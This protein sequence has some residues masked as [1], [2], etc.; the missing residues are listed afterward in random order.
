MTSAKSLIEAWQSEEIPPFRSIRIPGIANPIELLL[1]A[2]MERLRD[3]VTCAI[4]FKRLNVS[5]ALSR[6]GSVIRECNSMDQLTAMGNITVDRFQSGE[7]SPSDGYQLFLGMAD[8]YIVSVTKAG[9]SKRYMDQC[10]IYLITSRLAAIT[11]NDQVLKLSDDLNH[12]LGVMTEIYR[13]Y[14]DPRGTVH[15]F[16]ARYLNT[17]SMFLRANIA[18]LDGIDAQDRNMLVSN[19]ILQAA[20]NQFVAQCA[21]TIASHQ[22]GA[23]PLGSVLRRLESLVVVDTE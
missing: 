23:M 10:L 13:E 19:R 15:T 18:A 4:S 5:K 2:Q 22:D 7:I 14:P 12:L 11:Q 8:Y 21:T 1:E 20:L 16:V 9:A 6:L 17:Q 3:R